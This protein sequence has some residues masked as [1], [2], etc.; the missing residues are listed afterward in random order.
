MK[1]NNVGQRAKAY[2]LV[3]NQT[4]NNTT[5]DGAAVSEPWLLG[6]WLVLLLSAV[7]PATTVLT[8]KV[9]GKKRSDGLWEDYLDRSGALVKFTQAKIDDGGQADGGVVLGS[10]NLQSTDSTKYS[11]LRARVINGAATAAVVTLLG[12]VTPLYTAPGTEVDD[13]AGFNY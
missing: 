11:D 2:M 5:F 13:L 1:G 3:C 4:V 8:V 6:Q 10:V 7:I 12:I 9:Q